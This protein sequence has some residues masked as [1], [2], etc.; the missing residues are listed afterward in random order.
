MFSRN[1]SILFVE[2]DKEIRT[3][4]S[5]YLQECHFKNVYVTNNGKEGIACYKKHKPDIV[6][7]DL[8]MPKVDGLQMSKEIK[9][10]NEDVPIILITSLFEKEI[11]EAAVDIGIDAYLFKPI[12]TKRLGILIDKYI[13]RILQKKKFLNE[14][15]LLEEYRGAIDASSAVSKTNIDGFITYVNDSF[16]QMSGYERS[17]LIGQKN[18][19]V[20][21]PDT[22]NEIQP[23]IWGTIRN[24]NIWQ[25]RLKNIKKNGDTYYTYSVVVPIINE[26]DQIEEFIT[27]RQDITDLYHQEK[28]LKT[29]IKE[30]VDKNLQLHKEKEEAKIF[31]E[32][33]SLIGKMSAGITHEINTPL[34]YIKGNLELMI[35][36]INRLDEGIKQKAYLQEDAG[37]LLD[38]VNR[39][40]SIVESMREMASQTKEIS[41]PH[42]I[43]SSLITSLTLAYNKAKFIS[44]IKLQGEVFEI[45]MEK[46]KYSFPAVVQK[47]RIEQVFIIIINNALDVLK[48][49]NDFE[50]RMLEISVEEIDKY[51]IISFKD[52]AGGIKE[53]MLPKI[54]D[55][56]ESS[57]EEGGIGIG[58][59]VAKKIV[60]DHNGKIIPS[61]ID[62]GA[63]FEVYL[64]SLSCKLDNR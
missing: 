3:N 9:S 25:G 42:N 49:V 62:G 12:S 13:N 19:I 24:K 40:A 61:N 30:E 47:Q 33:F 38:G 21:H 58:L 48:L 18:S 14:H 31:E 36:D 46:N 41:E 37:T 27:F 11:T 43:Y 53:E 34:T 56:F 4:I 1:I 60:D 17:E 29:R 64:P 15:K 6:L 26:K 52:N 59:N 45:G 57:K 44:N 39:I 63:L 22:E 35:G 16:C 28:Y 20:K 32:K 50:S 2:D 5:K 51:I 54:F 23:N 10:L 7:T 8:R 55:P